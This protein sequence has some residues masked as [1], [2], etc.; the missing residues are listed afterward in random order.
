M[1]S[2]Y[3]LGQYFPNNNK[4]SKPK[5]WA[6]KQQQTWAMLFLFGMLSMVKRKQGL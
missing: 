2:I 4:H 1:L 3:Y 6:I 5:R